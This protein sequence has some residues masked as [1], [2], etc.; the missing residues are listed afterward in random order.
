[1][2][3]QMSAFWTSES[4][5]SQ[6]SGPCENCPKIAPLETEDSQTMRSWSISGGFIAGETK[7]FFFK[8]VYIQLLM[9]GCQ[10]PGN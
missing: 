7:G 8:M 3:I 5:F 2:G 9:E 4:I 10:N 1:M 6:G